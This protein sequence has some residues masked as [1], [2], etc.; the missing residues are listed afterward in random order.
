M[1]NLNFIISEKRPNYHR[2]LVFN[3]VLWSLAFA[4]LLFVFS[5]GNTPI[6]IDYI[7]TI[8]F[9]IALAIPASLNFYV[10]M[11]ML[12][13]KERYIIYGLAFILNLVLFAYLSSWFLE[14]ILD[15]L[16]TS[17]FFISY[18]TKENIFLVFVI[19]LVVSTQATKG[20]YG[21]NL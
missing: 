1:Q 6:A 17:F 16:F 13:K 12:L 18:L 19:F 21:P 5:K 10:F 2:P 8:S 4:I 3:G 11:P 20:S 9:I 15:L 14:P 7:Y